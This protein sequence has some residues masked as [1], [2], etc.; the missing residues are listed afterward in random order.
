M[1][2]FQLVIPL[3][4]KLQKYNLE[5]YLE[6]MAGTIWGAAFRDVRK[7]KGIGHWAPHE[8]GQ[9]LRQL[10]CL[11]ESE[12]I[13]TLIV[14]EC[15]DGGVFMEITESEWIEELHLSSLDYFLIHLI[16]EG[17]KH[18]RSYELTCDEISKLG[19]QTCSV[20]DISM[21]DQD[22]SQLLVDTERLCTEIGYGKYYGQLIVLGYSEYRENDENSWRPCGLPNE[23]FVLK[24]K[25]LPNGLREN[26]RIISSEHFSLSSEGSTAHICLP[27]PS[28]REES[29]RNLYI[30]CIRDPTK[31]VFNIGRAISKF[32]D[33]V[34]PGAVHINESGLLSG[35]VDRF[36]CRIECMRLPPFHCSI[37]AGC[38]VGEQMV[39]FLL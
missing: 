5:A 8:V 9:W 32:N 31:D 12:W 10:T 35:T 1:D 24:R 33:F 3:T 7:A 36:A 14:N 34:L 2:M 13:A 29:E 4:Q 22:T 21:L 38:F 6:E 39:K 28:Q 19:V 25:K 26:S 15:I 23:T 17:W 16:I 30:R 27:L 18:D 20:S 37:F 11:S